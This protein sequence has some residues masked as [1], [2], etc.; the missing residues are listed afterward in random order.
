MME[1]NLLMTT[2]AIGDI[3]G[4]YDEL[5]KLLELIA[6]DEYQDQLWFTG[7]L[8]N[9]GPQ[10]LAVLRFIK[11]L[12]N[13]IVVLGN[14]DIHLLELVAKDPFKDHTLQAVLAAPDCEELVDWLRR[15]RLLY[16]DPTLNY[17]IVH[18]GMYPLWSL[19][20]VRQYAAEVESFLQCDDYLANLRQLY[21]NKPD[22]WDEA[23]TGFER[24]R[25]IT[26]VLTRLRFC[27]VAGK[28]E[29]EHAGKVGSQPSGYSPWFEMMHP[30]FKEVSIIF[31]H[32]AA[33]SAAQEN[34][35]A[36]AL[37]AVKEN[38]SVIIKKEK[39]HRPPF[40]GIDTGCVWG[41]ALTALRLEDHQTFCVRANTKKVIS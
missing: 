29:F 36:A 11:Q 25:F 21:G 12:K 16:Y 24:L 34:H 13:A 17:L 18:A 26:N 4:C 14:H 8:V 33:L 9:R 41:G 15:Q 35:S 38:H 39:I 5:Q 27:T 3:H 7:D 23:L 40:F 20:Q 30:S 22:C 32:W 1:K 19:T 31:G 2:Y 37:S 6:F 10:S 28:L